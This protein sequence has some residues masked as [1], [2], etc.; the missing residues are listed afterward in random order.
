MTNY[1][2]FL[3]F[4]VLV[5]PLAGID[6]NTASALLTD[7]I[8]EREDRVALAKV[9][10]LVTTGPHY[11]NKNAA[12][13]LAVF[14]RNAPAAAVSTKERLNG[15]A[16]KNRKSVIATSRPRYLQ[17]TPMGPRYKNRGAKAHNSSR[18]KSR[19][20]RAHHPR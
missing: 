1:K 20:T 15:P 18:Y 7:T 9:E 10:Q 5:F 16:Y 14:N 4:F 17:P 2:L 13:R 12:G 3:L 19:R 6:A 11:K 8:P